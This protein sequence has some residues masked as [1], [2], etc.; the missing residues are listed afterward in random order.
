[1]IY[2]NP[3][4]RNILLSL[5]VLTFTPAVWADGKNSAVFNGWSYHFDATEDWNQNN[6]GLG[7]EYQFEQRSAWRKIAMVNTFRDSTESVSYMVG[8][9]LQKRL[10]ETNKLNG[11]HVYAGLNAFFMAREDVNNGQ[12]FPGIL[13]SITVGNEH[14]GINLTYLPKSAV[15]STTNSHF[16]DPTVSGILFMQLKISIDRLL[17]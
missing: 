7:Y 11:F 6:Y 16:S 8:A 9:G 17:Q 12:P 5:L 3:T 10:F 4:I 1:M 13:P 2:E 14:V 15:E